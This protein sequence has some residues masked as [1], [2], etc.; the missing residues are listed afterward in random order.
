MKKISLILLLILVLPSILAID[1]SVEQTSSDELMII[2]IDEP[3]TFNLQI[4][5]NGASDNFL[6][7]T[8]FGA[9][10]S[11]VEPIP[12]V[13]S[14]TKAVEFTVNPRSDM[15]QKGLITFNLFIQAQDGT[16][17]TIS[18][19]IQVIEL[20]EAFIVGSEE[21][22]PESNSLKIYIKNTVN[23]NF[24]NMQTTFKSPFFD[25]DETISLAPYEKKNFDIQLDSEDFNQ[26]MAGFYTL[27]TKI[28]VEGYETNVEG[29]IKFSEKDILETSEKTKGFFIRTKTITKE[30]KGNTVSDSEIIITKNIITRIFTSLSPQ[31]DIV[32]RKGLA[33]YYTWNEQVMPGQ[34]LEIIVTTNWFLPL[35]A[36]FL[37]VAIVILTKT[38]S[39]TDLVLKKRVSFVRAKGG[40]FA[41]KVSISMNTKN[42]VEKVNLIDRLP[43]LVRVHER[44]GAEQPTRVDETT[45]RIEWNFE[46]LEAGEIRTVSYIIYSKV[47]VLG[48]F[49]LPTATAIYEKEGNV[50]E[51]TS[52]K[53]FFIAEQPKERPEDE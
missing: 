16:E 35:I 49:A 4:T 43:P 9:G 5:N 17:E 1:I 29:T 27:E 10:S 52:N 24:E 14:E 19:T 42:Y 47:G 33:I 53:T 46:K 18:L 2:G 38:F 34:V 39:K 20:G 50:R 22:D 13:N 30:N 3:T 51:A 37:I 11:P 23:K 21:L 40:E 41:L 7:Y 36:I 48:K 45:K 26:I 28:L 15:T 12:I 8:F 6:F 31:P 25:I 32:E 44:F